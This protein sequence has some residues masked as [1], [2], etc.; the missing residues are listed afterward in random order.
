MFDTEGGR[1]TSVGLWLGGALT[2]HL[3]ARDARTGTY[4]A[5]DGRRG[6]IPPLPGDRHARGR[7]RVG[8]TLEVCRGS[9]W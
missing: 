7:G 2:A 9:V 8:G 4:E 3:A 5:W 6:R 1:R